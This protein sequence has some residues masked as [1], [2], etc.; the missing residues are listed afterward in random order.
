M[1]SRR[2]LRLRRKCAW[3]DLLQMNVKPRK[4]KVS[5]L[6]NPRRSLRDR[7]EAAK[8]DQAGLRRV[9]R[10]RELLKPRTHCIP[11]A[12]SLGFVFT[13]CPGFSPASTATRGDGFSHAPA[14]SS[15]GA[16]IWR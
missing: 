8:L 9:Q 14:E 7:R 15:T 16:P 6:P 11:E 2:V 1:R 3:R 4:L 12:S 10:P 5:G 13:I